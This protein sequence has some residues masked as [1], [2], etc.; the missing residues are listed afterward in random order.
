VKKLMFEQLTHPG[1]VMEGPDDRSFRKD[2]A[3]LCE[4]AWL[5]A[6]RSLDPAERQLL[7][8]YFVSGLSI[9]RLGPLYSVHRATIARRIRR[10]TERV[11]RQVR[12]SLSHH[13][14]GWSGQ[15]LDALMLG[16]CHDLDISFSLPRP[17]MDAAHTRALTPRG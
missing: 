4:Q 17:G 1:I 6:V 16:V 13:Y 15:D 10:T 9:D 8:H 11:R 5:S 14:L 7:Q 3:R 2:R 12:A